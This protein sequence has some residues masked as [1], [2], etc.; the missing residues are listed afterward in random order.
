VEDGRNS[1]SQ[2][3][4]L[5]RERAGNNNQCKVI[6]VSDSVTSTGGKDSESESEGDELKHKA[7]KRTKK[8]T[9][10]SYGDFLW[11]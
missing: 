4:G 6:G 9:R 8:N 11:T 10:S 1:L 5:N 2:E 7:S 3:S